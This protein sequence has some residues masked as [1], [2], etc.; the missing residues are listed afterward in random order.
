[1]RDLAAVAAFRVPLAARQAQVAAGLVLAVAL[2]G[3][4]A[5]HHTP[6]DGASVC[7][8]GH[9]HVA[10]VEVADETHQGGRVGAELLRGG[11]EQ[12][13]GRWGLGLTCGW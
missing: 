7:L 8:P 12:G 6:G 4:L 13:D 1:M 11:R 5:A 2:L 9:G 3:G 10:R